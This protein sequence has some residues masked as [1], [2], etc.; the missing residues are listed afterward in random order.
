MAPLAH[1]NSAAVSVRQIAGSQNDG[2]SGG[3]GTLRPNVA[4]TYVLRLIRRTACGLAAATAARQFAVTSGAL[5]ITSSS[6][7]HSSAWRHG[8]L[9]IVDVVFSMPCSLIARRIRGSVS[10]KYSAAT[11]WARRSL[12][13]FSLSTEAGLSMSIPRI[14]DQGAVA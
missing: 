7:L 10:K 9:R 8:V 12:T 14:L 3:V 6:R 2:W 1:T 4:N 13:P 5:T 11:L